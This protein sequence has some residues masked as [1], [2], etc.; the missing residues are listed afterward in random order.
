[1]IKKLK[2]DRKESLKYS[3]L[4]KVDLLLGNEIV[5]TIYG[6][7]A[8]KEPLFEF[9]A[10][11][12]VNQYRLEKRPN[13]IRLFN[14]TGEVTNTAITHS[15]VNVETYSDAG[16][17]NGDY[18]DASLR[19]LIPYTAL[20]LLNSTN[21]SDITQ[22]KIYSSD[23]YSNVN[24]PSIVYD[25]AEPIKIPENSNFNIQVTWTLRICN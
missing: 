15:G 16:S 6:H 4:V 14:E 20:S 23:N 13:F 19:F 10:L 1:M 22:L 12:I 9:L 11:C 21:S 2:I 24:K 18:A 25:L 3:G 8:G 17:D 5:K 7:N